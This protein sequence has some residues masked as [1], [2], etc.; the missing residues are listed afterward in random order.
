MARHLIKSGA[1]AGAVVIGL[2]AAYAVLRPTP[3]LPEFDP[4]A[5]FGDPK[6]PQLR[7]VVLGDSSVTA[8]GV[9]GPEEVWVSLVC[10]RLASDHH[11]ILESLAV[12]GSC[13]HDL[14]Q[15]QVGPAME[16]DPDLILVAVGANDVIRGVSRKRFE[17]NL[18]HLVSDLS[19]TG[20]TIILS[21]V[22]DLGTIP[23]LHPPLRQL[24]THRSAGFDSIHRR[25][26]ARHGAHVVEQ[27]ADH[28]KVWYS[29]RSLW[30]AVLF[31]VSAAGH[32]RWADVVWATLEPQL[33]G[34]NG[35][36]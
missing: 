26:A 17:R 15:H 4:S 23:R 9:S 18:D 16:F 7:V 36:L 27:R 12:G 6:S 22:G 25:V 35:S 32:R 3:L 31:H 1:I 2:E 13:A 20:A 14:I 33:T 11:V 5:S 24:F 8:P 10:Q 19:S 29:D 30:A 34:G 21:G 28:P